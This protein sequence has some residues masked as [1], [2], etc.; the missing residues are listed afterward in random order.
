MAMLPEIELAIKSLTPIRFR[1]IREGKT[2]E[3]RIGNPHAVFIRRL[4]NGDENVYLHLWQ[5]DGASD[6]KDLKQ[7]LPSWRQ[8][9]L[10]C[11]T[12]VE[13]LSENAP[14]KV[15]SDYIPTSYECPICII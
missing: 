2:A 11:I 9:F 12:D 3:L 7:P 15:C 5:T 1:Y 13:L 6:S 10:D 8:C 14:F 4:K